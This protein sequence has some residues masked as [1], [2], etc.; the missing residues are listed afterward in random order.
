[1][2]GFPSFSDASLCSQLFVP[3]L[4]EVL[5]VFRYQR[6]SWD[7]STPYCTVTANVESMVDAAV[8]GGM[9]KLLKNRRR[10]GV[11]GVMAQQMEAMETRAEFDLR[12]G[13]LAH[14][15]ALLVLGLTD[16]L[17]KVRS[18]C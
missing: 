11:R 12:A 8:A 17:L 5:L 1:M 18:F 7:I 9:D 3:L 14:D 2:I 10:L 16:Q 6:M 15:V 4:E 13:A